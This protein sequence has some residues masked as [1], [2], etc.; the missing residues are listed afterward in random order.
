MARWTKLWGLLLL[1]LILTGERVNFLVF[2]AYYAAGM[3]AL[4]VYRDIRNNSRFEPLPNRVPGRLVQPL[5]NRIVN[6]D[7]VMEAMKRHESRVKRIR[8]SWLD[9]DMILSLLAVADDEY[10]DELMGL[11]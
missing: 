9:P 7:P 10:E 11:L 1:F 4:Y 3:V 6:R 8:E 2:A 5:P